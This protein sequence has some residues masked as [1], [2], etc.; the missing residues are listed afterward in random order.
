MDQ[1]TPNPWNPGDQVSTIGRS[2]IIDLTRKSALETN[3]HDG[4]VQPQ[5]LPLAFNSLPR[6]PRRYF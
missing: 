4:Q 1:R 6:I 5:L 2:I 3:L